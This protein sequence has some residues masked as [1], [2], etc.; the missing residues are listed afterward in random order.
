MRAK[1]LML[2][3]AATSITSK[4]SSWSEDDLRDHVASIDLGSL[5]DPSQ[6]FE[7]E[8][9]RA[10]QV[11][12]SRDPERILA[13]FPAKPLL[14]RVANE[15]VISPDALG[16]LACSA[17]GSEAPAR[18]PHSLWAKSSRAPTARSATRSSRPRAGAVGHHH[19]GVVN[20]VSGFLQSLP[21]TGTY[22][23]KERVRVYSARPNRMYR[24]AVS[25]AW[26]KPPQNPRV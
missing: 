2:N 21:E 11:V 9:S 10:R 17:L 26:A 14:G 8:L 13:T 7:T 22:S 20:A 4:P 16:T 3:G 5:P 1:L 19:A 25:P 23:S 18:A 24:S 15:L 12:G 6:V